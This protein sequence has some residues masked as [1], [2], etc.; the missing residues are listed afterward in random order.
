[1]REQLAKDELASGVSDMMMAAK[2][3][4]GPSRVRIYIKPD[5]P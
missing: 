4:S 2:V 5:G 1:M 3:N